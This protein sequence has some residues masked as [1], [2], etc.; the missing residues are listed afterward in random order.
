MFALATGGIYLPA[1]CGGKV[2]CGRC[3]VQLL[4][5]GDSVTSLEKLILTQKEIESGCRL[6]CQAK[7][8]QDLEMSVPLEVL[9]ANSFKAKLV[10]SKNIA[11]KTKNLRFAI[12]DGKELSFKSG[13]YMQILLKGNWE[14]VIRAYSLSSSPS[15]NNGFT[16]DVQ[17]VEGGVMSEYLHSIPLE[18]TLEFIG[19]FGD[20]CL[21]DETAG[22]DI[23]L[24][25]G[26]VGLAPMRSIL[27]D[28]F[29][30][31]HKGRIVLFHGA[32]SRKNLAFEEDY[33]ALQKKKESFIY[34]PT[35][36]KPALEDGWAGNIGLVSESLDIWLEKNNFLKLE[37][38]EAYICG[39]SAMMEATK[40][41]LMKKGFV[42]ARIHC[43]PFNF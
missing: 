10:E 11:H 26:G 25:A 28:L 42:E 9:K 39:N 23:L 31:S 38:T 41:V 37:S 29:E 27:A 5:G 40:S 13:Q 21:P 2:T 35:L 34:V 12:E 19:P 14:Q 20:M 7:V 17:L 15:C 36:S 16:L 6:A 3:K 22:K 32:M 1:A 30:N 4:K 43:D 33:R 18:T 8:R 24:V